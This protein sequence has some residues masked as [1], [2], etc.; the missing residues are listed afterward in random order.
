MVER[1]RLA[2]YRESINRKDGHDMKSKIQK[3]VKTIG[4]AVLCLL[5]VVILFMSGYSIYHQSRLKHELALINNTE[6]QF[7]EIEGHRMNLYIEG[8]G[9]KTL[10]FLPGTGTPSP[11]YDFKPLYSKLTNRY[12][13]VVIEPFGYGYSDECDGE[14]SL[15]IITDQNREALT[16]AGLEGPYILVPHS[17]SGAEA[18]WWANNYPD[19]VEAIIGLDCNI[20]AQ[21]DYYPVNI[22]DQ[23]PIDA[24]KWISSMAA[25]DFFN[26]D[27]GLFRL[28]TTESLMESMLPALLSDALTEAEKEQYKALAYVMYCRGSGATWVRETFMTEHSLQVLREYYEGPTPDIPTLMFVSDGK[29]MQQVYGDYCTSIWRS[30]H[31]DYIDSLTYGVIIELDSGHYLHSEKPDQ[32]AAEIVAFIDSLG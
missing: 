4:I 18:I 21:Y 22:F 32:V 3:T 15:D 8:N 27:V 28:F 19:E 9:D 24:D 2:I 11:M 10:V 31:K 6:G 20:P 12:R 17:V 30:I 1:H 26:Y 14:R 13:I 5:L 7:V 25:S 29:V 16:L 23:D